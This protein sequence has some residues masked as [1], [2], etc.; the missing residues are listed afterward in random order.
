MNKRSLKSALLLMLTALIW[1]T[2]FIAQKSGVSHISPN[3]YNGTRTLLGCMVLLPVIAFRDG[4][5]KKKGTYKPQD[6]RTLVLGGIVCGTMLCI[7][8]TTQSY[9]LITA[10]AGKAG[11]ITALYIVLVPLFGIFAHKKITPVMWGAV[12]LA[13]VG[14]YFLC[15]RKSSGFSFGGG[16]KMLL[17]CAVMFS[18]HILAVDY[19]SPKTD[20]VKLSCIQFFVS[21]TLNLVLMFAMGEV[22]S[23]ADISSCAFAVFYGGVMSCGVAYTLQIVAQKG[24]DPT[25]ASLIMSLESLF[26][27]LA[28]IAFGEQPS[29]RELF[30]CLFMMIAIIIVQVPDGFFKRAGERKI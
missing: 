14:L 28:G 22:P 11:F 25:V 15:V 12:M 30:G 26:A 19:F 23:F 10:D 5:A 18:L 27:L 4:S 1:G 24:I 21:A 16:E 8:S 6:M 7:A 17:F 29:A 20:G 13:L 2:A 3:A 9:G